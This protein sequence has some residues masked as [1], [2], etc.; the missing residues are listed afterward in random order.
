M[1]GGAMPDGQYRRAICW[2]WQPTLPHLS[3]TGWV[4]RPSLPVHPP[5]TNPSKHPSDA[6]WM[7]CWFQRPP[8]GVDLSSHRAGW[9]LPP[10]D[11]GASS[12]QRA[13]CGHGNC[14]IWVGDE[15][16]LGRIGCPLQVRGQSN[17]ART[18]CPSIPCVACCRR[19]PD[20]MRWTHV[21]PFPQAYP[22]TRHMGEYIPTSPV[23]VT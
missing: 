18:F 8:A 9:W 7:A 23:T 2:R 14:P 22:W 4:S 5:S 12:E 6:S 13:L 21:Q 11:L 3:W 20:G 16:P 17:Q 15:Y 1:A 10:P 19:N